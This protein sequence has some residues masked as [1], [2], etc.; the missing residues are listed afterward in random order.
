MG[1]RSKQKSDRSP[2]NPGDVKIH[3]SNLQKDLPLQK[4]AIASIVRSLC[5]FLSIK[6]D[7]IGLYFVTKQ[8]IASL[9]KQFFDD[10]TPTDCITFPID[11]SYLGEIFICPSMALSYANPFQETVLYVVHGLLHL[12]GYDDLDPKKRL[13]MRKKEK[14]CMD[15]LKRQG[16]F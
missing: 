5:S 3:F 7:E 1:R 6:C 15:F 11:S 12:L 13:T 10:P 2:Q 8:K 9:H 4:Q 16:H 14:S